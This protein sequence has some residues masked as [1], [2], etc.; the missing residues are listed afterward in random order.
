[1]A[2]IQPREYLEQL[3]VQLEAA[4]EKADSITEL[5]VSVLEEM[6]GGASEEYLSRAVELIQRLEPKELEDLL[7][8]PKQRALFRTVIS[9]KDPCK[10][11]A[12]ATLYKSTATTRYVGLSK[13]WDDYSSCFGAALD[14]GRV[15]LEAITPLYLSLTPAE[16]A[17]A[18]KRAIGTYGGWS[19]ALKGSY[20]IREDA[21]KQREQGL[22]FLS[23]LAQGSEAGR[24]QAFR[25]ED[26]LETAATTPPEVVRAF[27]HLL[28][29]QP[30][31]AQLF[32]LAANEG[33]SALREAVEKGTPESLTLI[34]DLMRSQSDVEFIRRV[35]TSEKDGRT[36][37][38][39]ALQHASQSSVAKVLSY[40]IELKIDLGSPSTLLKR[41]IDNRDLKVLE[42]LISFLEVEVVKKS[43]TDDP[44]IL[45]ECCWHGKSR[46]LEFLMNLFDSSER[47][48]L[49]FGELLY[50]AVRRAGTKELEVLA[51]IM[52]PER[53]RE[54]LLCSRDDLESNALM[55]AVYRYRNPDILDFVAAYLSTD[56]LV[57]GLEPGV[58]YHCLGH[59]AHA[60]FRLLVSRIQDTPAEYRVRLLEGNSGL[61]NCFDQVEDVDTLKVLAGL[62]PGIYDETRV[63]LLTGLRGHQSGLTHIILRGDVE[64]LEYYLT[65]FKEDELRRIWDPLE[66]GACPLSVALRVGYGGRKP[67]ESAVPMAKM[68]LDL[69]K[70]H[71][72]QSIAHSLTRVRTYGLMFLHSLKPFWY[73]LL[74]EELL[75]TLGDRDLVAAFRS[76]PFPT[77]NQGPIQAYLFQRY[78][79]PQDRLR[80]LAELRVHCG[81]FTVP[82]GEWTAGIQEQ[83]TWIEKREP[84]AFSP[85]SESL[86]VK[87]AQIRERASSACEEKKQRELRDLASALEK[88][89]KECLEPMLTLSGLDGETHRK[90]MPVYLELQQLAA[91][92]LR[93]QLTEVLATILC[94][95]RAP[96]AW[97]LERL[98]EVTA[99]RRPRLYLLPLAILGQGRMPAS[100]LAKIHAFMQG[101]A[102]RRMRLREGTSLGR[103]VISTL[104][105]LDA[106]RGLSPAVLAKLTDDA[107]CTPDLRLLGKQLRHLQSILSLGK[108]WKLNRLVD[109]A[110]SASL[111]AIAEEVFCRLIPI[112]EVKDPWGQLE[113]F[114]ESK[115]HPGAV[116]QYAGLHHTNLELREAFG[117]WL[118]SVFDGTEL[119][120]RY[121]DVQSEHLQRV[122][123]A[124]TS[125]RERLPG[126]CRELGRYKVGDLTALSEMRAFPMT[127]EDLVQKIVIDA[128]V[129]E[130]QLP[131]LYKFLKEEARDVP[132]YLKVIER[133]LADDSHHEVIKAEYKIQALLLKMIQAGHGVE[134]TAYLRAALDVARQLDELGHGLGEF[135]EDLSAAVRSLGETF[136]GVSDYTVYLSDHYLDTFFIGT[137]VGG[138]CQSVW[139]SASL[140]KCLMGYVMEGKCFP[141][142]VKKP[143][144]DKILARRMLNIELEERTGRPALFLEQQYGVKHVSMD[145]AMIA[146]AKLVAQKLGLSLYAKSDR[147]GRGGIK[148][149]SYPGRAPWIY[150]DSA[151]RTHMFGGGVSQGSYTLSADQ[152]L[153]QAPAKARTASR[154]AASSSAA[155]S[156]SSAR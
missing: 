98:D 156:S 62:L 91:P 120:E 8:A 65:L 48:E 136:T 34:L 86:Q 4:E 25:V 119:E 75:P 83:L 64:L 1:M 117:Q 36:V 122:Y 18:I 67:L 56:D 9:T 28:Q 93:T 124:D 95:D 121:S 107:L 138:S 12:F 101:N 57:G 109:G 10:I 72:P 52:G 73:P 116:L 85:V 3:A 70:R 77:L 129:K 43:I 133:V 103:A 82:R 149:R 104:I 105:S 143:G 41:A 60:Q 11:D 14:G 87:V 19:R 49:N 69:I 142:V 88:W 44:N 16:Q 61:G 146:Y 37:W 89:Q 45:L 47:E 2:S 51:K 152:C 114:F 35:L 26:G 54:E 154:A 30:E 135:A 150:S 5:V 148:L 23:M 39:A 84:P 7:L 40:C 22:T 112:G 13:D 81:F 50:A 127:R 55:Q 115:R 139:R 123:A 141:I 59:G 80:F 31:S 32:Q 155:C 100:E 53:F 128:H 27:I 42:N 29:Q 99:K 17:K 134:A 125:L 21:E 71:S 94:G 131:L 108:G 153:Y 15:C 151:D 110:E 46:Q 90:L 130:S 113:E 145:R 79:E 68:V 137:D 111:Q 78:P 24:R 76:K 132:R 118:R 63:D 66:G 92:N 33:E 20:R 6:A 96:L 58:L 102:K 97:L 106:E 74:C 144:E 147:G 126:L 38:Q 140:N